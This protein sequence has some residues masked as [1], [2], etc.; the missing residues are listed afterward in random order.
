MSD[1]LKLR[2][3]D[4]AVL[5]HIVEGHNDTQKITSKTTLKTHRIR[6]SLKKLEKQ[7]LITVKQ[8]DRMV[9]RVVDG[10]KRVFQHPKKA[11]L[12][13]K[14]LQKTEEL[15]QENLEAFENMSHKEMV[16]RIQSLENDIDK[17]QRS[18]KAFRKQ[19]KQ[20]IS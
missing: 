2:D 3:I 19:V 5:H 9:E 10:Q 1:D 6:Y 13:D 4:Q 12:T 15:N 16:K 17:L 7:G 18:F 20:K 11:E 14:G 8:P